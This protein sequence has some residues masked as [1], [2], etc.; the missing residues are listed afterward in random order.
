[1]SALLLLAYS[2]IVWGLGNIIHGG[3][4]VIVWWSSNAITWY[5]S[6]IV[7][8]KGNIVDTSDGVFIWW[9]EE[10]DVRWSSDHSN[11]VWGWLNSIGWS[12]YSL[13]WWWNGNDVIWGSNASSIVWWKDNKISVMNFWFIW[14]G[15]ENRIEPS[16][17][18]TISHSVIWWWQKNLI[19]NSR[20]IIGG[21]A[22]H[23][24]NGEYS[25]IV[26]WWLEWELR[27]TFYGNTINGNMWFIGWWA[28]NIINQPGANNYST[29]AGGSLNSIQGN[30]YYDSIV[31]WYRNSITGGYSFVGWW[32]GNRIDCINDKWEIFDCRSSIVW[33]SD[34]STYNSKYQFIWWGK[35]NVVNESIYSSSIW[36]AWNSMSFSRY[37]SILWWN[38]NMM[39]GSNYVFN[40]I[41]V[42]WSQNQIY[43]SSN[44]IYNSLVAGT[45]AVAGHS[46]TFVWNSD[47]ANTFTSF[48]PYTVIINAPFSTTQKLD[49]MTGW[50]GINTNDPHA[51]LDVN[52]MIRTRR[53][54]GT[55]P[56]C[57][58]DIEWTIYFDGN[59]HRFYGCDGSAWVALN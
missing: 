13:V 44:N 47:P 33:W 10:N 51:A 38:G 21:W 46:H 40:S 31:G 35:N 53:L 6:T 1:M 12:T 23:L 25:A 20:S 50:V 32:S 19:Q 43:A 9:W 30:K 17:E 22:G 57:M 11:I 42:W 45:G 58:V 52:G 36:G 7:G 54:I 37:G 14:W 49:I 8:G 26:W 3:A 5:H 28:R 55:R 24:I 4:D 59:D 16:G 34:N 2:I 48:K 56:D 29:I 27:W 18:T 39:S 41:I 15:Q